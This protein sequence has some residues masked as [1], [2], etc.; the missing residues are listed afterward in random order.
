[1]PDE[2]IPLYDGELSGAT[3]IQESGANA[4]QARGSTAQR[5]PRRKRR[6]AR[7]ACERI[8]VCFSAT[9]A[10]GRTDHAECPVID[11]SK[12]GFCIEFDRPLPAGVRVNIAY[13]T[14]SHR[15]VN[16]YGQV[17]HCAALRNGRYRLGIE[18]CRHL[19]TEEMKL[20]KSMPARDIAPGVHPRKLA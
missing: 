4:A 15:P 16:V 18:L 17:R 19:D 8:H 9:D 2:T 12:G 14:I 3:I 1:M 10:T 11:V 20:S 6:G 5:G 7:T 13:H